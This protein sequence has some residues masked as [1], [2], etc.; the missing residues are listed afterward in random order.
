MA[1][2]ED[3]AGLMR[4]AFGTGAR[5]RHVTRLPGASKKGVYRVTL[6]GGP[7]TAI[8]YVWDP[9]E[10]YWPAAD[11]ISAGRDDDRLLDGDFPDR[12][13]M[14]QIVAY[15]IRQACLDIGVTGA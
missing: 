1:T 13:P 14:L 2:T 8:V 15:N 7:G 5:P 3:L 9:G 11:G 10:D 4:S 12:G 6:D